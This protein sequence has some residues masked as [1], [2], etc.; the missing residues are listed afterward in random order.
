MDIK[1]VFKKVRIHNNVVKHIVLFRWKTYK[2]GKQEI[3]KGHKHKFH[4][5]KFKEHI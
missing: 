3:I 1:A 2:L 5:Q 4:K